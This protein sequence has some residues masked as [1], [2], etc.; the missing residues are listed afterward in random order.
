MAGDLLSEDAQV[1]D[2]ARAVLD[3][4]FGLPPERWF[5]KDAAL[6]AEIRDRF[7]ALRD[8]VKLEGA[9]GWRDRPETLLAAIILLDQFSRNLYRGS[10]EAFAADDL[11]ARLTL[12]GIERGYDSRLT[13]DQSV[14]LHMPLMHAEDGPLQD[15]SVERF[16]ALG[17]E[18][19]AAYARDHRDVFRRFGR[20]P[21][22]NAA[23]GRET[24]A[25]EAAWLA[26]NDGGW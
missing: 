17:R 22:R 11:A 9:H 18:E 5:A 16:E 25:E 23:L 6:D 13:P 7:A 24:T 15:L 2:E 3:F 26:A 20:F 21:G 8:R 12:L 14:F 10:P 19:N 1:H 4:W